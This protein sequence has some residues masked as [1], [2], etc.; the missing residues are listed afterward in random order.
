LEEVKVS[1]TADDRHT[2]R[3]QEADYERSTDI[4]ASP[5]MAHLM[6]ALEQGKDIGHYGRLTFVMVAR[7]F[8]DDD[9]MVR[10][11]TSDPDCSETEA[12]ELIAQVTGHGYNPPKRERILQWQQE[13]DFPI[14]PTPDDPGA[15]NVYSEI[16][17]PDEV[18][19]NISD[20]WEEKAEAHQSR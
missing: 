14:C 13:Q 12:R 17:F 4:L 7:F 18:Y 3:T 1:K 6:K 15:C 10:L 9:E 19:E 5:M 11:L 2:R 16:R 8:L 20:F